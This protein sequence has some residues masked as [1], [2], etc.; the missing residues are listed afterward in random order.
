MTDDK[1][2]RLLRLLGLSAA[3][4]FEADIGLADPLQEG[5]TVSSAEKPQS[6]N[7]DW[8]YGAY[9]DLSYILNL[10]FPKNHLFR[11]RTTTPR[12]NEP[13][14]NM[15]M[16]YVRKDISADSRWGAEFAV[17]GGYDSKD[18]AFGQDRPHVG[19]ADT[20]RHF[21]RANMSYLAPVG[22]GLTLTAGLFNSF[23]GYESLYAKDNFNYTRSWIAD[24]S[25]YMMFGVGAKYP[26]REQ[27]TVGL[28]VINGYWH[29]AH[30]NNQPSYGTQF[31]W[32]PTKQ[33]TVTQNFY[34]GPDQRNTDIR[35][36]RF[37]SDSI[38]QW[39][40]ETVTIAFSY[41]IGTERMAE[42]PDG[43]RTFWT[44]AA[45]FAR[46]QLAPPWAVALRPEVYWDRH[47]RQTGFEQV[48]KA[49]TSTVEY[50]VPYSAT[51]TTFRLEYRYDDS[52]GAQG[53]F[54]KG[55]EIRP[56]VMGLAQGQHMLIFAA[57]WTYD[58]P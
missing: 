3:L 33:L 38:L 42:R 24:N 53:G 1:A 7:A 4:F 22:N 50:K 40:N 5:R 11:T 49:V 51:N 48:V 47:G 52:T 58:S 18:F 13:A 12:T 39:K 43:L 20:L 25:P 31:L 34:Y 46:W 17:Q 32:T 2:L 56:G 30:P 19:S 41:D 9:L 57:L 37:F 6:M 27:L 44:G 54:F 14:P 35:Y 23:I 10:N 26:V 45:L 36:W 15:A 29:L 21:S 55:G 8:H 16:A 28:Y